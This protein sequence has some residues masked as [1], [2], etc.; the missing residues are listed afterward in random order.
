MASSDNVLRGGLTPKFVDI[1]ELL[2]T[3]VFEPL[4]FEEL[5]L[6]PV[7]VIEGVEVYQV[8]CEDFMM[9]IIDVHEAK[10]ELGIENAS[11]VAYQHKSNGAD[12]IFVVSGNVTVAGERGRELTLKCGESGFITAE[13]PKYSISGHGKVAIASCG[14]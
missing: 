12:I 8:P 1:D 13:T 6:S 5:K 2:Y 7:S 9:S 14:L 10:P 4:H 3:T 11:S